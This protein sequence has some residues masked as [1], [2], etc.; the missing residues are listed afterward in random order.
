VSRDDLLEENPDLWRKLHDWCEQ[1]HPIDIAQRGAL[2]DAIRKLRLLRQSAA[3]EDALSVLRELWQALE[4]AGLDRPLLRR[5]TREP[6]ERELQLVCWE[7][8]LTKT[9]LDKLASSNQLE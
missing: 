5:E 8:I 6:S 7:L 2:P 4:N 1:Y 9:E 3:V